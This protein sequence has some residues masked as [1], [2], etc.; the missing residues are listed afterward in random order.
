MVSV[1][2]PTMI[3]IT[4]CVS[5]L[6]TMITMMIMGW[7]DEVFKLALVTIYNFQILNLTRIFAPIAKRKSIS[8]LSKNF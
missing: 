2:L 1:N 7:F 8:T 4:I 5:R 6:P 3:T